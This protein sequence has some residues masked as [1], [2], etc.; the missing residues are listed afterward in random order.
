MRSLLLL[1]FAASLASAA[2]PVHA[3]SGYGTFAPH[4]SPPAKI[5]G[6]AFAPL[7]GSEPYKPHATPT[8]AKS[9][10]NTDG[11]EGFKPF[12]PSSIYSSSSA[13]KTTKPKSIYDH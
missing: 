8:M 10:G 4:K 12:K 13:S 11:G 3:Q 6:G 2:G 7:P 1:G 5:D 9:P